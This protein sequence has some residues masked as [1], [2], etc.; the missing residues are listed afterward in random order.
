MQ[1]TARDFRMWDFR[2]SHD[3]LL[4]RSPK[5]ADNPRNLDVAF[6]GVE[7][8]GLPTM[9]E[10]LAIDD[11]QEADFRRADAALGVAVPRHRVFV[12]ESGARR[13]IVVAAAM[14]VFE[15]DLDL[16]ESS[17]ESFA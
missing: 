12:I 17:L 16:F 7:F 10:R 3:Q 13:Y 4:L 8:V 14:K 2:V 1:H 5:T 9:L 11:A 6:V 15:N